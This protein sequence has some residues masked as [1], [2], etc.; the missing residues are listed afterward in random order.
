MTAKE[1]KKLCRIKVTRLSK[2][3]TWL[4]LVLF[5][6]VAEWLQLSG[7]LTAVAGTTIWFYMP[8]A[9]AYW[10]EIKH[11]LKHDFMSYRG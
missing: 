6:I 4:T 11:R 2:F 7:Y 10:L 5:F 3:Y 9:I 8:D 1:H